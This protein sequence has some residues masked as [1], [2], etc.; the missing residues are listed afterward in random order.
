MTSDQLAQLAAV[1][2]YLAANPQLVSQLDEATFVLCKSLLMPSPVFSE[3]QRGFV[4]RWFLEVTADQ[5]SDLESLWP[6]GSQ[7]PPRE[8]DGR[9][10]LSIDL[11][12]DALDDGRLSA[13]LPILIT[14]PL[15]RVFP[16]DWPASPE[17]PIE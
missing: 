9:L 6:S 2:E 12:S 14:C 7:Y 5:A 4:Q 8:H 11:L 16:E 3:V 17:E 10:L 13:M 15:I 1:E